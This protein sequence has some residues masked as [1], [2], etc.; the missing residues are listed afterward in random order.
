MI[1][2]EY[3]REVCKSKKQVMDRKRYMIRKGN[4]QG[5]LVVG[6]RGVIDCNI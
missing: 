2:K 6:V 5:I 3:R 1:R 4:A